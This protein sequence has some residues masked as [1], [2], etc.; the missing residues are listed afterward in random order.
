[1][2]YTAQK[3]QDEY[4]IIQQLAT[5]VQM[6]SAMAGNTNQRM[7]ALG[8]DIEVLKNK[9]EFDRIVNYIETSKASNHRNT[10]VWY[11]KP[12]RIFKIKIPK[13]RERYKSKGEPKGGI[14]E[15]YHGSSNSNI[16]SILSSGLVVPPVNAAH[17][18]G[19]NFGPGGYFALNS[20]KSL[21]YSIGFWGGRKSKYDNCFLFLANVAL[22]KYYETY[23]G[24][25]SG[26]PSG[27]DSIWARKGKDLYND[28]IITPYLENQTLTYLVEMTK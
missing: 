18:C 3:L 5:G 2:I 27:Y 19:R 16:Y 28:E 22:G 17:V 8:T 15:A 1:M 9:T 20:S 14:K 10:D 24:M 6:G 21:N 25:P 11:Y 4:D 23:Y 13:E 26:T 7:S 12:R